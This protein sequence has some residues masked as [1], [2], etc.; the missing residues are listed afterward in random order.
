MPAKS[1]ADITDPTLMVTVKANGSPIKDYYPIHTISITHEINKIS[2]AE[3][4]LQD[5]SVESG[6]FP[7]SDSDDFI[8]GSEIEITAGYG[9]D[10]EVSIFKGVVVKQSI[11]ITSSSAYN[12]VVTCK[13]KAVSMTFNK[14]EAAFS[15]KTDSDIISAI[16]GTY[17]LT[18]T[19]DSTSPSIETSFQKLATDWDFILTRAEFNGFIVTLNDDAVTVGK[20][21]FDGAAVLRV[22]FGESIISFNAELSAEKQAPSLE[23]TAW[24]IKNQVLLKSSATEPTINAQGNLSAKDLSAKLQ[25]TKLSLNSVTPMP[26]DELKIW[27]DSNLLKM[28]LGAQKGEVTFTGSALVKTGAIIELAGV[29]E[30]FNGNAFVSS[31]THNIEEGEWLTTVKFGLDSRPVYDRMNV[32]YPAAA[33]QMPAIHGLHVATVKK[34][35]E[36]PESQFRIQISIPSNAETQDGAW[37]RMANFYATSDAGAGFLPEVGDE[38]IVGFLESNPMYPVVLGSLY[39]NAKKAVTTPADNNNYIKALVTK[40]KL[41][42]SFD[43]EKKIV[44]IETPAGNKITFSDDAKSIEIVD[45]NSNSVKMTS[46]GINL[47]SAKDINIKATGNISLNATGKLNLTA[48]QDVAVSGLN[49]KNTANVGFTATGNA[50]AEL[51]ASGQTTVKGALVMIN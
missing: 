29:G 37:A 34:L 13:H 51:S 5:G 18:A 44:L 20:P 6:D 25:Q 40:S 14:K 32:S 19:V 39:S 26:Q 2:Y 36:D 49:I 15:A 17:G 27:A 16:I 43:D 9:S 12:L 1:P 7:I 47:E 4:V 38:V 45:Q 48:T 23:A 46:S 8:P 3:I 33:G 35:F 28:R 31:V 24:D 30:R 42:L 50:T 11:R 22:A 41:K 21:K 10:A